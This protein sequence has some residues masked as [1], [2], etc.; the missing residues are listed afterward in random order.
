MR[1]EIDA[2]LYFGKG[3]RADPDDAEDENFK[4]ALQEYKKRQKIRSF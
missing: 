1:R 4:I 2:F 3:G